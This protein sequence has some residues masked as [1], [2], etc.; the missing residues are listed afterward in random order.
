MKRHLR[1]LL[2]LVAFFAFST[3]FLSG[4][5]AGGGVLP[6]CVKDGQVLFF[7]ALD[8]CSKK[9]VWG[10]LGGE[11]NCELDG[12]YVNDSLNQYVPDTA[13]TAARIANNGTLGI[14]GN[15]EHSQIRC[16]H[17][18]TN[19]RLSYTLFFAKVDYKDLNDFKQ[20]F[21]CCNS[22]LTMEPELLKY[23]GYAWIKAEDLLKVTSDS[24]SVRKGAI[25]NTFQKV[26]YDSVTKYSVFLNH[27]LVKELCFF[28]GKQVV[29]RII[30]ENATN[31]TRIS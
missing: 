22:I 2:G 24:I 11:W 7:V 26:V 23:W 31:R 17:W 3:N 16:G 10:D 14:F 21:N 1:F 28:G 15:I 19:K 5:I 18:V 4:Y 6:Y 9:L 29:Q 12:G 8:G 27:Y 20:S 13:K 30:A 25:V